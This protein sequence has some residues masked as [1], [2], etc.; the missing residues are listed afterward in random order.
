MKKYLVVLQTYIEVYDA[1]KITNYVNQGWKLHELCPYNSGM[2][3]ATA[4]FEVE[5]DNIDAYLKAMETC[6]DFTVIRHE[7]FNVE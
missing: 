1:E 2:I 7:E 5:T 6:P 3:R 4:T